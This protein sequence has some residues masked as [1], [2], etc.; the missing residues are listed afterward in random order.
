MNK[1]EIRKRLTRKRDS[2]SLDAR[3]RGDSLIRET[4]RALPE[5]IA[6]QTILCYASFRS[7]V[8]T[9]GIM[10]DAYAMRK[11]LVLP[12]VVQARHV[13]KLYEIARV[14]ELVPGYRE[15]MEP[16]AEK[17]RE[18]FLKDVSMVIVPGIAFDTAGNRLGYGG[19]YY[20]ILLAERPENT[21]LVALAYEE[22]VLSS[23]PS[24]FHDVKMDIVVT[25]EKTI[26]TGT[27]EPPCEEIQSNNGEKRK[28]RKTPR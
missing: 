23:L 21:C 14:T 19:G 6:A 24:E 12:K 27:S 7:E 11:R 20:D 8:G 17:E 28:E 18:L 25:P 10:Q 22:Q 3:K 2:L 1:E 5:F 9:L 15:I 13:L 4:L 26:R 16:P